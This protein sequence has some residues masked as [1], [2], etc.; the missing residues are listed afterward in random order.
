MVEKRGMDMEWGDRTLVILAEPALEG[1]RIYEAGKMKKSRG[2][3]NID[4]IF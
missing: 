4:Y 3:G 2:V 1:R